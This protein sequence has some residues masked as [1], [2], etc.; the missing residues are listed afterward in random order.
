MTFSIN[1][2]DAIT[3]VSNNLREETY[4]NF[5]IKKN[6]EVIYNF[7]DVNRFNK[8]PVTPFRQVIAP[9]NEKIITHASNFRSVKRVQDVVRVFGK[10]EKQMSAKLLFIG[11][12]PDRSKVEEMCRRSELCKNVRFLGRQEEMEDILAITDLFILPSSYE[13]FGLVA[14]EA[15]AAHVPVISSNAGGLPEVNING[16]TGFL[17]DVGDVDA[18]AANALKILSC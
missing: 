1:E 8:K 12:G 5:N 18:M 16:E 15:M 9:D 2:S 13:S 7:V 4:R 11:D 17:S 14:L 3:A 6:I 10:I